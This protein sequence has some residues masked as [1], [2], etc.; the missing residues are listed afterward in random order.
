MPA[1]HAHADSVETMATYG[2]MVTKHSG[3]S[4]FVEVINFTGT[5]EGKHGSILMHK[6]GWVTS[7][8]AVLQQAVQSVPQSLK[9]PEP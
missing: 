9:K 6:Q 5:C 4:S 2:R 3:L 8:S 7:S 1:L